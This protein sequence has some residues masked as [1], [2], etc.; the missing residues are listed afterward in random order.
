M[1]TF[2][3]SQ[4]DIDGAGEDRLKRALTSCV[5]SVTVLKNAAGFGEGEQS[6]M[7][8]CEEFKTLEC[9]HIAHALLATGNSALALTWINNAM[10][11]MNDVFKSAAKREAEIVR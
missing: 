7:Q 11:D 3:S 10:A 4:K 2:Q 5:R 6:L 1:S 8:T 9:L